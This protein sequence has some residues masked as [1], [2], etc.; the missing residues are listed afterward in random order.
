MK[1]LDFNYTQAIKT[2]ECYDVLKHAVQYELS[3][4]FD[5]EVKNVEYDG[6]RKR[7]LPPNTEY[8]IP[9]ISTNLLDKEDI[10]FMYIAVINNPN[11]I[12]LDV[13][14]GFNHIQELQKDIISF[15]NCYFYEEHLD[16][17]DDWLQSIVNEHHKQIANAVL[18]IK[19]EDNT[20]IRRNVADCNF[21]PFQS[22]K[23][24]EYFYQ[25]F[26]IIL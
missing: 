7:Y 19:Q 21:M 22:D 11:H 20:L 5:I 17:Y 10:H 24:R 23:V 6:D 9:L 25:K 14:N 18:I 15:K 12:S 8:L 4:F 16:K 26:K 2:V 13:R 3:K 1:H